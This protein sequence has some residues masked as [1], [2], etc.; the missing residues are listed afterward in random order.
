M[1]WSDQP[2]SE[3]TC[4]DFKSWHL[5]D[6]FKTWR[7]GGWGVPDAR[8]IRKSSLVIHDES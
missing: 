8:V 3:E 2:G 4:T 5:S 6:V 1:E 7:M